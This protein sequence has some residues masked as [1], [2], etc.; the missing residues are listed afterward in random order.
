MYACKQCFEKEPAISSGSQ[1]EL[2]LF[3]SPL[4]KDDDLEDP[5]FNR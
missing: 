1:A 5:D 3:T 4:E 2:R